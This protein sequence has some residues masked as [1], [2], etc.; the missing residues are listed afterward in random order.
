MSIIMT[1]PT[2]QLYHIYR[3]FLN[4]FITVFLVLVFIL[5]FF[6]ICLYVRLLC[7]VLLLKAIANGRV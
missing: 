6:F 1:V 3:F 2:N 4:A 5:I 7:E